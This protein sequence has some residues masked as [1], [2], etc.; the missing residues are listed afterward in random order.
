[1]VFTSRTGRAALCLCSALLSI[2]CVDDGI[3]SSDGVPSEAAHAPAATR[4]CVAFAAPPSL[5]RA[6]PAFGALH[7]DRPT[8][9]V[10]PKWA[11]APFYVL[12]QDGII[13]RVVGTGPDAKA[14][15]FADLRARVAYPLDPQEGGLFAIAFSPHFDT[16][17]DVFLSY[18]T[19]GAAPKFR[20][21]ITRM[22][23]WDGGVTLDP[24]TED[25]VL[26]ME[27]EFSGHNGGQILFGPDG[28]LYAGLGDGQ[29]GD[30]KGNAQ[31]PDV[32]FGKVLRLDVSVRPYAIP[33]DNPFVSGSGRPE[34]YALGF[35]NPWSF[36]FDSATGDLWLGDTGHTSWEEID[37]VTKGANF[38]WNI[39]E[40][41]H[42]FAAE[43]CLNPV[44]TDPVYE[45]SHL[46]GSAVTAGFVYHGK[47]LPE[48]AGHYVFAD[49]VFGT[50]SVLEEDPVTKKASARKLLTR[51]ITIPSFAEDGDGELYFVDFFGGGV[52]KIERNT[53]G[54]PLPTHL[55]ETG[56]VDPAD[57]TKLGAGLIPY[58]I[59]VPFW[60]DGADK[61]RAFAI[62]E[63]T[64]VTTNPDGTWTFPV[65]TVAMKTFSFAGR[66]LETRFLVNHFDLLVGWAGYTYEWND[67]QTD[68]TLLE[69]RK[70]TSVDGHD[71][72]FPSRSECSFCHTNAGGH[73]L[74][75][76]A[77]QLN[78][79]IRGV[80]G[81]LTNQLTRLSDLGIFTSRVDAAQTA[82]LVHASDTETSIDRRARSWLHANCSHCHQPQGPG[83]GAANFRFDAIDPHLCNVTP[84]AGDLGVP[85]AKLL[86]PG[87]P[88]L[89]LVYL[90]ATTRG[91]N[92]MPPLGS[93]L[94]DPEGAELLSEWITSGAAC[95]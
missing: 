51:S 68:A 82:K 6:T 66:R 87:S 83:Q 81:H 2:Q 31:N 36:S 46:D 11:N 3:A 10:R 86:T 41:S 30:P 94:V 54:E 33:P 59:N 58:S 71:W 18:T 73:V 61:E 8:R 23:S 12:Q 40:G 88:S 42:C 70:T 67:A 16:D 4:A 7:F 74:G 95:P 24:A 93:S 45:Y 62:P 29:F 38:G 77:A 43:T 91:Q 79:S 25:T 5:I 53:E 17:N 20:R 19:Y 1:M 15:V 64:H 14:T 80:D 89:S 84:S 47:A 69:D 44:L 26:D 90:R 48:L 50:L 75:L 39:R 65:G 56:C 49:Y 21:V 52:L 32:L 72:L 22:K 37:R 28:Y 9:A 78:R 92:Q 55:T 35:R 60:S 63:G 57:P 76:Q 13:H 27:R 85:G 34:I